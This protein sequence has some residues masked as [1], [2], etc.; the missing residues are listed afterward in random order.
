VPTFSPLILSPLPNRKWLVVS[1]FSITTT[2]LGTIV[3]PAG[4]ICDLNSMPRFMWWASTP[5]DY[6]EAGATHD[7]LYDQQVPQ[8]QADAVYLE[9]L[10]ASG[11]NEF[12]AKSRYR[13]LRLFGG[14]AYRKHAKS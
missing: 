12:R 10:L 14:F 4:F 6:P 13:A 11:M 5:T 2:T 9:I 3:V 8:A 1:D 7:Y